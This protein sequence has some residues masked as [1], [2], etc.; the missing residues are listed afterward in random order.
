MSLIF[1]PEYVYFSQIGNVKIESIQ[2]VLF[3]V[4]TVLYTPAA[5]GIC[6]VKIP[7]ER[8]IGSAVVVPVE[9]FIGS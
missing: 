7:L 4:E 8:K 1:S 3:C 5:V 2:R 9:F 6:A